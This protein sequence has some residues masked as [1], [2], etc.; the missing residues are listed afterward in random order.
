MIT[1]DIKEGLIKEMHEKYKNIGFD[2]NYI[3]FN[4]FTLNIIKDDKKER[5]NYIIK[6]K[7][8]K[9]FEGDKT[10]KINLKNNNITSCN[11]TNN[12]I[13]SLLGDNKSAYNNLAD[14]I[15]STDIFINN[16]NVT[17]DINNYDLL[18]STCISHLNTLNSLFNYM[19]D[20]KI[21]KSID[22]KENRIR[23]NNNK[24]KTK[25]VTYITNTKYVIN[26]D[27]RGL[28]E[29]VN[30]YNRVVQAWDVRGHFR[31]LKGGKKVWINAYVKGDKESTEDKIYKITK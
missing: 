11:N 22:K 7:Y 26:S 3:P 9:V 27:I 21:V 6:D 12:K 13:L 2:T 20:N 14:F 10:L 4:D 1:I 17:K 5:H 15:E 16:K 25:K 19:L 18:N 23:N 28:K 24:K 30:S 8:I 31:T 29:S